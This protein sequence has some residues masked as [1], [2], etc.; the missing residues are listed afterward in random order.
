MQRGG[1]FRS[2]SCWSSN[3]YCTFFSLFLT[4]Q[5]FRGSVGLGLSMKVSAGNAKQYASGSLVP[6]IEVFEVEDYYNA[7]TFFLSTVPYT[8]F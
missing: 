8:S 3:H 4:D 7:A 6:V 2:A 5:L 1:E